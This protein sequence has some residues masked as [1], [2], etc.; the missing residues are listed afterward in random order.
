MPQ[1]HDILSGFDSVQAEGA[2][3]VAY[4]SAVTPFTLLDLDRVVALGPVVSSGRLDAA[5]DKAWLDGG[6]A[7]LLWKRRDGAFGA[8]ATIGALATPSTLAASIALETLA[9]TQTST[10]IA[11][12]GEGFEL[13]TAGTTEGSRPAVAFAVAA[14]PYVAADFCR[15]AAMSVALAMRTVAPSTSELRFACADDRSDPGL[16]VYSASVA[17]LWSRSVKLSAGPSDKS[18]DSFCRAAEQF[19]KNAPAIT[20]DRLFVD[21]R[22]EPKLLKAFIHRG[23]NGILGL[24]NCRSRDP[25]VGDEQGDLDLPT[26]DNWRVDDVEGL[27]GEQFAAW[28]SLERKLIIINRGVD[29]R[30]DI[31]R[32]G[33]E[34]IHLVPI[35]QNVAPLG[36]IDDFN[37]SAKMTRVGSRRCKLADGGTVGWYSAVRPGNVTLDGE[38]V[39]FHYD[40]ANGLVTFQ[41]SPGQPHDSEVFL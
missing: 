18:S 36:L 31:P 28:H 40:Q 19:F 7:A 16:N 8:M 1:L 37:A 4:A 23:R 13:R 9:G 26:T 34:L 2:A 10:L 17:G 38:A 33:A 22:R 3:F 12:A 11:R 21:P 25:E 20:R 29:E 32:W 14:N 30:V 41:A 39:E 5:I 15:S 6:A 24:F 27:A 35:L